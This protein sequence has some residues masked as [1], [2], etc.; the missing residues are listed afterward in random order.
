MVNKDDLKRILVLQTIRMGSNNVEKKIEVGQGDSIA[1]V[2]QPSPK[3]GWV[4]FE[5]DSTKQK[6]TTPAVINAE[7]IQV[8]LERMNSSL[9]ENNVTQQEP[10]PLRTIE[11]PITTVEPI[12]QGFCKYQ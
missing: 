2:A 11:L 3:K 8:N 4:K 5:E 7:S 12:R 9:Q 1:P 10:K 6:N